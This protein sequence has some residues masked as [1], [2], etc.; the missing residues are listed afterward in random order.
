MSA[1]GVSQKQKSEMENYTYI[2]STNE[3]STVSNKFVLNL[4][5]YAEF[6]VFQL[7]PKI[8]FKFSVKKKRQEKLPHS[9]IM[10]ATTCAFNRL[11]MTLSHFRMCYIPEIHGLL[12]KCDL[13]CQILPL[14]SRFIR[15]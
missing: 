11:L 3:Q 15:K 4:Y 8:L 1:A 14:N 7:V 12:A 13:N 5:H 10:L 6:V 9:D 2:L